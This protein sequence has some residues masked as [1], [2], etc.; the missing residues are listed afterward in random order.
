MGE[1]N[2]GTDTVVAAETPKKVKLSAK[3]KAAPWYKWLSVL[4][5]AMYDWVLSWANSPYGWLALFIIAFVESS[6]F[7]IP[8]DVLLIALVL[9]WRKKAFHLAALCTV[10]SVLGAMFGYWIGSAFFGP[11]NSLMALI[12]GN[13]SWYGVATQA[14]QAVNLDGFNFFRAPDG[15]EGQS[16]FLTVKDLYDKNAFLAVFTAAFTPIPFKVFTIAGGYFQVPFGTLVVSSI[17]GR[18]L[19]FFLVAGLLYLFG[20]PMKRLIEKYFDVFALVFM[21]LLIGGFVLIGYVL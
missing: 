5:R 20:E 2:N 17:C 13:D 12:I 4:L 15:G 11:V 3:L 1:M 18:A 9:G 21:A 8:P 7:P 10:G 14:T 19:R 16:V 6:F